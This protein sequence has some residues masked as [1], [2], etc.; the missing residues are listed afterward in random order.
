MRIVLPIES[1]F[2]VDV[3]LTGSILV[4][5]LDEPF[6]RRLGLSLQFAHLQG[7]F[8][9]VQGRRVEFLAESCCNSMN[10]ANFSLTRR[11][12]REVG[13]AGSELGDEAARYSHL[14]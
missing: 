8:A 14:A 4:D 9:E 6:F 13:I 5:D 10:Y 3:G 12:G 1:R 11:A 7:D 2:Y